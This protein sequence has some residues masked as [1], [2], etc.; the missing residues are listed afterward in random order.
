MTK[1]SKT[2][3]DNIAFL[4]KKYTIPD[5]GDIVLREFDIV[6]KIKVFQPV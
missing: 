3:S 5:N 4:K 1:V 2:L 6:A